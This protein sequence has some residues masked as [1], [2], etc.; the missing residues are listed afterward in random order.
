VTHLSINLSIHCKDGRFLEL[1][2]VVQVAPNPVARFTKIIRILPRYVVMSLLPY[3][4]RLW[5]DS[6]IFQPHAQA[7]SSNNQS[8]SRWAYTGD[9]DTRPGVNQYEALWGRTTVLE[10]DSA[11]SLPKTTASGTAFYVGTVA[12]GDVRPFTLPDSR[13]FRQLR[14]DSGFPWKLCSS[15]SVDVSGDH[16][17]ANVEDIDLKMLPHPSTRASSTY[18]VSLDSSSSLSDGEFGVW[19]ETEW[20]DFRRIIVKAVK[21]HS[22]AFKYTDI[23]V[24][25]ELLSVDGISVYS[26]SFSDAIASIRSKI[27]KLLSADSSHEEALV[28][29]FRT[30][31]ERM[32]RVRMK[33]MNATAR[34]MGVPVSTSTLNANH[35]HGV[36]RNGTIQHTKENNFIRAELKTLHNMMCLV[37]KEEESAPFEIVNQSLAFK[38]QYRQKG[39]ESFEWQTLS[40]GETTSFTWQ[41][42]L[43]PKRLCVRFTVDPMFRH[44]FEHSVTQRPK[45][46]S[47]LRQ[48]SSQRARSEEESHFSHVVN[49]RLEEIGYKSEIVWEAFDE[50]EARIVE[51]EVT[52]SGATRILSAKD[53]AEYVREGAQ[54]R[55][56]IEGALDRLEEFRID[57][58][59]LRQNM[60]T[61]WGTDFVRCHQ[62]RIQV[63]EAK[64]L[65]TTSYIDGCN[66]YAEVKLKYGEKK[67]SSFRKRVP[68]G[69]TYFVKNSRN[70]EWESQVFVFDI[71]PEAVE[72]PKG[73][74][75]SV[76][77]RNYRRFG[78]HQNLGK[79]H[80]DLNV[81]RN[82]I[83]LSGWF[84][85][86]GRA[87]RRELNR[88]VSHWGRGSVHLEVHWIHSE[89]AWSENWKR[90]QSIKRLQL[91]KRLSI[92]DHLVDSQGKSR[93][94]KT[95]TDDFLDVRLKDITASSKKVF[96]TR[97][98]RRD[99]SLEFNGA[100]NT[101]ERAQLSE[102]DKPE[103]LTTPAKHTSTS[104]S[105]KISS[106]ALKNWSLLRSIL[107]SGNL[108]H[109]LEDDHILLSRRESSSQSST[110][111]DNYANDL[112]GKQFA[113]PGHLPTAT[114]EFYRLLSSSFTASRESF[115]LAS[116]RTLS[117][118]LHGGGWITV[119]PIQAMNLTD[120]YKSVFVRAH[121]GSQI[122]ASETIDNRVGRVWSR[123][124]SLSEEEAFESRSNDLNL[125]IAPQRTNGDIKVVVHGDR[126]RNKKIRTKPDLGCVD[127][128]LK[129][130]I[131]ACIEG[132]R[133]RNGSFYYQMW[134]PL[135]QGAKSQQ[136]SLSN[137]RLSQTSSETSDATYFLN[138][139]ESC[140]HLALIWTPDDAPKD[141]ASSDSPAG[142][143][144]KTYF[145][146]DVSH[147]SMA[148]IDSERSKE[149]ISITFRDIDVRYWVTNAK[150]RAVFSI[151]FCQI[152]NQDA[153]ARERVILAP[154]PSNAMMPSIQFFATKDN[155]RSIEVT[156]FDFI[157]VFV[158]EFDVTLEETLLFNLFHLVS[159]LSLT[160]TLTEDM[161]RGGELSIASLLE[162]GNAPGETTTRV[163]V[164]Q[165]YLGEM[166]INLSYMKG[167]RTS[168]GIREKSTWVDKRISELLQ[169]FST[170]GD[171]SEVLAAWSSTPAYQ[172]QGGTF[173]L[174]S[175]KI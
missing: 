140:L 70:P 47:L 106:G 58:T 71:P 118:V 12:P 4:V 101:I 148:L 25:D 114:T 82:E 104:T 69:T 158:A 134:Y 86:A 27:Q 99:S 90:V 68:E 157:D 146:A 43:K 41:E 19:Y 83:P 107:L 13:G 131:A 129:N 53:A 113:V 10:A 85:L 33:A 48:L 59:H 84:P 156:S 132:Q 38:M 163:Y 145:N 139:Y 175:V 51:V 96:P 150:T 93:A 54:L 40:P 91:E 30:V 17:L 111:Q 160:N 100:R 124:F 26:Y 130:A 73:N 3:P 34:H 168:K 117:A 151:D 155:I 126:H 171:S 169:P 55:S 121:Y 112:I 60:G 9:N 75:I 159:R 97:S 35:D 153:N 164:E 39:C 66:P 115:Q 61:V 46:D 1:T 80:L 78:K 49:V 5:Q 89:T 24:G 77:L 172:R 37:L 122:E 87:G 18:V 103:Q 167:K 50:N 137:T 166:R 72:S 67:S 161:L 7:S 79:V 36:S 65:T 165:L 173:L 95:R 174:S 23:H 108:V 52:V 42:P 64:G 170:A 102:P 92:V 22:F 15:F 81:L 57:S 142:Q 28:L 120:A 45:T 29:Q 14:I 56:H 143:I 128:P 141:T 74:G 147:I 76:T 98:V 88:L 110:L 116:R 144:V 154:T 119:R 135:R 109:V 162:V 20:D 63:F 2:V 31:E 8:T 94:N 105:V 32:R 149:L 138:S 125:Y 44:L 6:S 123:P 21:K 136:S 16:V 11:E 133:T 127:L 62:L 152:D